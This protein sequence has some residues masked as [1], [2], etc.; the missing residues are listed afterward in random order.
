MHRVRLL[1]AAV[2]ALLFL[3]LSVNAYACLFPPPGTTAASMG[4]GCAT[5]DEQSARQLCDAFKTLGVESMTQHHPV[6]DG[7]VVVPYDTAVLSLL[8]SSTARPSRL[9]GPPTEGPPQNLLLITSVL[10]I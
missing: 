5:P 3:S 4:K 1:L 8:L 2:L 6:I 7:H 9:Y 10:R